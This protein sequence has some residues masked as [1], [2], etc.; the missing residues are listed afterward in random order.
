MKKIIAL[1]VIISLLLCG[2]S[3]TSKNN[4]K[5]V[6]NYK[7]SRG[8]WLSFS[9]IN[10]MLNS[11]DFKGK[12]NEC[13]KNLIDINTTDI[14]IHV[15][16]YCDSIFQSNFF[17]LTNEA[18]KYDFDI[19]KYM[20]KICH[21]NKI[22]VHAWL[23]PYRVL[24]SSTDINTLQ[25]DSPV[26]KWLTDETQENDDNVCFCNG[27]YLNPAKSDVNNL[28]ISGIREILTKYDVDGIHF[29]DY[30]YPTT[31]LDFDSTT[32][33]KYS[34]KT[35]TP[36]SI[37]NWRRA[38][39]N[40]LISGC[41]TAIKFTNKD[42]IF[43]ISPAASITNNYNNLYADV[44]AWID[45]ECVDVIIPQLYFG[46]DYPIEEY[47]FE[48]LLNCWIDICK[49]KNVKLQL[50]LANYKIGCEN[51]NDR[52]EWSQK[53]DII[54]R[55]IEMCKKSKNICGYALFSYSSVFSTNELNKKQLEK[56][57]G[58]TN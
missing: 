20:I 55:Q 32:Y 16:S 18:K 37:D 30:F 17:P 46:F 33:N 26:K 11:N 29:D 14:Y 25:D 21:K 1:L 2:C 23:N 19:F 36:L 31:D 22:R 8:V 50:G 15:R 58:C 40:S 13:V 24:T 10:S 51:E 12:F 34:E 45:N 43:S 44:S 47:K 28:V 6:L 9:E 39:V 35:K 54:A 38:N 53:T 5:N 42:I 7:F 56:I 3:R 27:I 41:Y 4:E 49:E 57:K 52:E 48:N